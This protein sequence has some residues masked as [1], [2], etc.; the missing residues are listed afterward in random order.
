MAE[1]DM[2]QL[3]TKLDGAVG[4]LLIAARH[5]PVVKEAMEMVRDVS[6]ALGDIAW[7]MED[8]TNT[9][10]WVS[11]EDGKPL[12]GEKV[13]LWVFD[14]MK[15]YEPYRM[16]GY[17]YGGEFPKGTTHWMYLVRPPEVET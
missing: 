13:D 4:R 16:Q 15:W 14:L 11:V 8:D 1:V 3:I 12:I 10:A 17:R 9:N 5:D 6:I 7:A 2:E